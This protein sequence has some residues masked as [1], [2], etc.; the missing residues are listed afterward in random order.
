MNEIIR[1]NP[2]LC[3]HFLFDLQR[4]N[5]KGFH[6]ISLT[7]FPVA[8]KKNRR[9]FALLSQKFWKFLLQKLCRNFDLSES[10]LPDFIKFFELLVSTLLSTFSPIPLKDCPWNMSCIAFKTKTSKVQVIYPPKILPHIPKTTSRTF[11]V[12]E[13]HSVSGVL[14][15]RRTRWLIFGDG[16]EGSLYGHTFPIVIR[17]MFGGGL[18]W[19]QKNRLNYY[20]YLLA[21]F[22]R[23]R[24]FWH[25]TKILFFHLKMA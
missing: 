15:E 7:T 19:R 22:S 18:E 5:T 17:S 12:G 13:S 14:V 11:F 3:A 23:T 9:I 8:L 2:F 20:Q 4:S 25:I 6:I 1:C 21:S 24:V 10:N 16:S